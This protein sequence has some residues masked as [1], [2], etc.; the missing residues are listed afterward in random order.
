MGASGW[1]HV[2]FEEIKVETP[3]AFLFVI[4][5]EDYWIP[6]SQIADPGDYHN[7]DKDGTVSISEWIAKQ[8]NLEGS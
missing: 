3:D 7:G 1:V 5:G 4:D 6:R 2:D 8:K